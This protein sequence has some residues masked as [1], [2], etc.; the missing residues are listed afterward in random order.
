VRKATT[1]SGENLSAPMAAL[2]NTGASPKK[3]RGDQR[4]VNA[5]DSTIVHKFLFMAGLRIAL[6][7]QRPDFLQE[8]I[9]QKVALLHKG[10]DLSLQSAFFVNCQLLCCGDDHR[11]VCGFRVAA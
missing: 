5:R 4:R 7:D 9:V 11:D 6:A 1:P 3:K 8:F 10:L 2:P